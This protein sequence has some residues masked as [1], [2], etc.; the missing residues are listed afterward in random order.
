MPNVF[1]LLSLGFR[2]V[3]RG[4]FVII[5][6]L[7]RFFRG[8]LRRLIGVFGR[9]R[10]ASAWILAQ[11]AAYPL[12]AR[13]WQRRARQL[14]PKRTRKLVRNLRIYATPG[15]LGVNHSYVFYQPAVREVHPGGDFIIQAWRDIAPLVPRMIR[16][17]LYIAL[18]S[19]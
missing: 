14:A 17:Q 4:L 8:T 12:I 1:R 18:G 9:G 11:Q 16:R 2:I 5:R 6:G 3:G 19:V 13:L 15:A 10:V 7:Y